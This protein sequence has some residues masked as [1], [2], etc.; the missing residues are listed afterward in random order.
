MIMTFALPDP[1]LSACVGAYYLAQSASVLTEDIQRADLG[2]LRLLLE[3]SGHQDFGTRRVMSRPVSLCGPTCTYSHFALNGPVRFFG[4]ILRPQAWGG[5]IDRAANSCAENAI[6]AMALLRSKPVPCVEALKACPTIDAMKEVADQWLLPQMRQIAD[7][8]RRVIQAIEDWLAASLFPEVARLY[9]TIALSE[10]QVMRIANQHFGAPP[11]SLARKYGA[12]RTARHIMLNNGEIP[13]AA[14]S[15][16]ADKSHLIREVKQVTGQT[17]RQ[18]RTRSNPV[19]RST[20]EMVH[21]HE[22]QRTS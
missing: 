2:H 19:M 22:N 1:R 3:G 11:K 12:L 17:P 14:H 18:L 16:Y 10:R 4:V 8:R 15:H 9:E 6:D 7:D 21:F 13:E 20:L 5:L